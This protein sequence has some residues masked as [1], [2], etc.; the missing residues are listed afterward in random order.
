MSRGLVIFDIDGVVS[1]CRWR[2]ELIERGQLKEFHNSAAL[3]RLVREAFILLRS[4]RNL[5]F[6][7]AFS[8]GRPEEFRAS[9]DRWLADYGL[10]QYEGLM[11]RPEGCGLT[12]PELKRDHLRKFRETHEVIFA[13]DDREDVVAMYA[14][15][16]VTA[17]R[18]VLPG[19]KE[20]T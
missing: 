15:E 10:S 17:L 19:L 16:R 3:D 7:H 20:K 14:Q 9:T 18:F 8:T 6:R 12:S 11:M 2:Q 4:F 5:G 1:D 13:V